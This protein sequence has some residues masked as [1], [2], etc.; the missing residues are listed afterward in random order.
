MF[1]V[2]LGMLSRG[3]TLRQAGPVPVEILLWELVIR[4]FSPII[5]ER[6][7]P[8]GGGLTVR[9]SGGTFVTFSLNVVTFSL[10]L[11]VFKFWLLIGPL[12]FIFPL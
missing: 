6:R 4:G 5:Y 8:T 1:F 10:K 11:S 2:V 3:K 7:S 12:S 9:V